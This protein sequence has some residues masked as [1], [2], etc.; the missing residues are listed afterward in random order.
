MQFVLASKI[1]TEMNTS[2]AALSEKVI[3]MNKGNLKKTRGG[4]GWGVGQRIPFFCLPPCALSQASLPRCLL[5]RERIQLSMCVFQHS[6]QKN[7]PRKGRN[8]RDRKI[9]VVS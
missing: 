4:W 3:K 1:S 8:D 6:S 2:P 5:S 9:A 7:G